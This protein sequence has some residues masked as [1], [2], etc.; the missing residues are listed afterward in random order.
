MKKIIIAVILIILIVGAGWF[1]FGYMW[2]FGDGVK[3]G[4]LKDIKHKGYIFKTYEGEVNLG[5]FV[6]ASEEGWEF[7]VTDQRIA[8]SLMKCTGREVSLHYTE[9]KNTLPWR[10]MQRYIVDSIISVR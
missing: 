1:Y 9:Y 7:S 4:Q 6:S 5:K 10:G 8:D 3:G 2:P